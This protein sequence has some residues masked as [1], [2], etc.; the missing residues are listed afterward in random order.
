MQSYRNSDL[1][2]SFLKNVSFFCN[3]VYPVSNKK[4]DICNFVAYSVLFNTNSSK[5][6]LLLLQIEQIQNVDTPIPQNSSKSRMLLPQIQANPECCYPKFKQIQNVVIPN[7]SKSRWLL[8]QIQEN[9][10]RFFPTNSLKY[11]R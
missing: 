3:F 1:C 5:S 9:P 2:V 4:W 10:D 7:L 6:R 11:V 8:P